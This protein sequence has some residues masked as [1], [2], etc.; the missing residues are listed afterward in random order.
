VKSKK[1]E[2]LFGDTCKQCGVMST[3]AD[4]VNVMTSGGRDEPLLESEWNSEELD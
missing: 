2:H 3:Y 4:D 1:E